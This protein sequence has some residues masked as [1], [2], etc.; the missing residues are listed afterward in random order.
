MSIRASVKYG[1]SG[2]LETLED[3]DEDLSIDDEN[4]GE[5]NPGLPDELR[6]IAEENKTKLGDD[7]PAS[8]SFEV[9]AIGVYPPIKIVDDWTERF[10]RYELWRVEIIKKAQA[11]LVELEE[12]LNSEKWKLLCEDKKEALKV[13]TMQ[14]TNGCTAI[15][16]K[17]HIPDTPWNIFRLVGNLEWRLKYDKM[18]ES[19]ANFMK[20]GANTFLAYQKFK[21]IA[22]VASR[23]FFLILHMHQ[24]T[25]GTITVIVCNHVDS[26]LCPEVKGCVRGT[27]HIASWKL[28]PDGN[29]GC[30]AT[31]LA[32]V[33]LGGNIPPWIIKAAAKDQGYTVVEIKK[34]LP[35]FYAANPH[36]LN[37]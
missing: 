30:N 7:G 33:D 37:E 24:A 10:N 29:G 21:R 23:D 16:A 2:I 11:K 22:I 13:W 36:L 26:K 17:G 15:L 31:Y 5:G 18:Y 27:L 1:F 34:L 3:E 32:E 25:D 20:V 28:H 8:N 9:P 35:K 4:D 6:Q 19:G 14:T 12:Y